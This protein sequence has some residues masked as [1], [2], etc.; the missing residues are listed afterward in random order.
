MVTEYGHRVDGSWLLPCVKGWRPFMC[1]TSLENRDG[2][3]ATAGALQ[4]NRNH[5]SR[6]SEK[7]MLTFPIHEVN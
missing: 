3:A 1:R 2:F 7:K 4:F 5:G 6:L